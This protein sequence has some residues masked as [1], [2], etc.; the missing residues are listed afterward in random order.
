MS[1]FPANFPHDCP[2]T[3]AVDCSQTAF[4]LF[5]SSPVTEQL[6]K[7]QAERNRAANA[8]GEGQCTR[9]GLSVFPTRESCVHQFRLFPFL[10]PYIGKAVLSPCHGKIAPTPSTR[11]PEHMTWWSY[12][13]VMRA[14]LF[15]DLEEVGGS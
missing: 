9:H 15:S 10:G 5:N 8:T 14:P 7:T 6:C 12:E 13:G 1:K 4:M 2:L 11:N 3:N